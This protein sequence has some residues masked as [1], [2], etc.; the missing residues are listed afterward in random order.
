MTVD[1][2]G[3]ELHVGDATS[4]IPTLPDGHLRLVWDER[5]GDSPEAPERA[6]HLLGGVVLL[7]LITAALAAARSV[8]PA[9][10][11]ASAL[12]DTHE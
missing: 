7:T 6:R 3:V 8:R 4:L 1:G 2:A 5:D 11:R 12:V 10:A 9:R